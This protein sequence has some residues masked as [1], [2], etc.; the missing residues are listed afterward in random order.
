MYVNTQA[1]F[2]PFNLWLEMQPNIGKNYCQLENLQ[3]VKNESKVAKRLSLPVCHFLSQ[4]SL[5]L[6]DVFFF[7]SKLICGGS[8]E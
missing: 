6:L 8:S 7:L 4:N 2:Q 5:L 1:P 3:A